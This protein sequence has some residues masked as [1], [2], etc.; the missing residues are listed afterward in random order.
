MDYGHHGKCYG[1]GLHSLPSTLRDIYVIRRPTTPY[2]TSMLDFLPSGT[3]RINL[4]PFVNYYFVS[5]CSDT[6]Q[7][8]DEPACTQP[9]TATSA[10]ALGDPEQASTW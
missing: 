2:G 4:C 5:F 9:Q 1:V 3:S 10:R 8:E 7:P 6:K